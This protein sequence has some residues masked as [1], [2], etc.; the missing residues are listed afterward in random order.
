MIELLFTATL[1]ALLLILVTGPLGSFVIWKRI[2]YFGDTLAH[3]ALLGV[4]IGIWFSIDIKIAVVGYCLLAAALLTKFNHS[5]R[6][7]LD[8]LLGI[9]SHGSLAI[10]LVL[11]SLADNIFIDLNS[12]LFGDLLAVNDGDLL[13]IA[14]VCALV[15]VV[16][17][18]LWRQLLS[19]TVHPELASVEG[20]NVERIELILLLCL[21]LVVAIGMQVVGVLLVTALLIIPAATARKLSSS[22]EQMAFYSI[23]FGV[24]AV[25][26]GMSLSVMADSSAGPSIVAASTV[27]FLL[28]QTIPSKQQ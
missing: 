27:I 8:T 2:A 16:I 7:A 18:G 21:A 28:V 5:K 14:G 6:I 13:L 3:S 4:A 25:T 10:G 20:I 15:A 11:L 26:A 9:L 1:A 22:P 23:L 24:I 12:L 19:V 17:S